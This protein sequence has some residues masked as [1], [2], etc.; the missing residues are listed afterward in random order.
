VPV[1]AGSEATTAVAADEAV[2]EPAVLLAVTE[3]RIVELTSDEVRR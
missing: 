3:R 1:D 2:A